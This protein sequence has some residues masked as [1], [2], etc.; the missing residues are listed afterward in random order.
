[1][2]HVLEI[3]TLIL[4]LFHL[5]K[6]KKI[7]GQLNGKRK[8]HLLFYANFHNYLKCAEIYSL[9]LSWTFYFKSNRDSGNEY[10]SA[11]L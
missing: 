10:I 4:Q 1:V 11:H 6:K 9:P 8:V 3:S 2:S 5:K 7:N